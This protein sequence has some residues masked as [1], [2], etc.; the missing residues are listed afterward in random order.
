MKILHLLASPYFTGPAETV[1]QLALRQRELGHDVSVAV[2]RKRVKHT[3]EELLVPRLEALSLLSAL[4]L[5]LCVKS[6]PMAMLRDVR[7]LYRAD[8]DVIHSHFT[9]DHSIARLG[10][11]KRAKLI[12]SFHAPRSIRWSTP[13]AEGFTV[14]TEALARRVLGKRVFLFPA[15]I[16]DEYRPP[17]D[18]PRLRRELGLPDG[19]LL[20]MVS[21]FQLSRRH[22]L[23]LDAFAQLQRAEPGAHLILVGDGPLGP[24]LRERA[25]PNVHFVGYQSGPAFVR[26]LQALD[27]VW[28]LGLGNDWSA[29]AAAQARACDVRVVAVDEG[30]LARYADALVEP[31]ID[32]LLTHAGRPERRAQPLEAARSI[33]ERLTAFYGVSHG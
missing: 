15:L 33:A 25:G 18:R 1:T 30:A 31:T 14:P 16:G 5:E 20:G 13:K 27:E 8:V 22:L 32:S 23:A 12:R 19:R 29:R 2:D 17:I 11:P 24:R 6:T 10:R 21:T 9:H 3:S 7:T 28:L 26:F 4:P